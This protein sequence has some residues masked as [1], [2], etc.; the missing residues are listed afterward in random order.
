MEAFF[1]KRPVVSYL[2]LTFFITYFFWFLPAIFDFDK[3][4]ALGLSL[5]GGCG[6]LL[7]GYLIAVSNSKT[8][9]KVHSIPIFVFIFLLAFLVIVLRLWIENPESE[10]SPVPTFQ[11]VGWIAYILFGVAFLVLALNASNATSK[12]ILENHITSFLPEKGKLR[13]YILGFA[14]VPAL[15]LIGYGIGYLAKAPLTEI[16]IDFKLK[17]FVGFLSTLL[18]FGGNEEFGWRGFMQKEMQKKQSPLITALVISFF[19]SLWHLPLHYNGFYGT[20]GI[21]EMLPRFVWM[22]PITIIYSWLY[23]KSKYSLLALMLMH[24]SMNNVQNA[25]GTSEWI[26]FFLTIITAIILVVQDKMWKRNPH[27]PLHN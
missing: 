11:K 19:W 16:F 9:I 2:L 12:A 14:I 22:I 3:D 23:N 25:F 8:T 18:F 26:Y 1:N 15:S 4:V 27:M 5:I 17:Y 7:A 20:G 21:V 10:N 6:P 24:A 13:W